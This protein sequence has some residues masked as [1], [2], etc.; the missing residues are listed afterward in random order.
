MKLGVPQSDGTYFRTLGIGTMELQAGAS[1]RMT[2]QGFAVGCIYLGQRQ[3]LRRHALSNS[4]FAL[5]TDD[6]GHSLLVYYSIAVAV[7]DCW[8]GQ[9]A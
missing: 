6:V 2:F 5:D 9:T 8:I 7:E 1:S 3:S 4:L